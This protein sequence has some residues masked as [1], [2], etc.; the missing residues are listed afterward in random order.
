MRR[1]VG[2]GLAAMFTFICGSSFARDEGPQITLRPLGG[3]LIGDGHTDYE[4]QVKVIARLV[5]RRLRVGAEEGQVL[6]VGEMIDG[7]ATF[8]YKP[9]KVDDA[10]EVR[11]RIVTY[12]GKRRIKR[13]IDLRV[14][15]PPEDGVDEFAVPT[16]VSGPEPPPDPPSED[17]SPSKV[18]KQTMENHEI[19]RVAGL[20]EEDTKVEGEMPSSVLAHSTSLLLLGVGAGYVT[21]FGLLGGPVVRVSGG[22]GFKSLPRLRL[23]GGTGFAFAKARRFVSSLQTVDLT[24]WT[25][26]VVLRVAYHREL[27]QAFA[28]RGILMGGVFVSRVGSKVTVVNNG[29]QTSKSTELAP[30]VGMGIGALMKLGP[31]SFFLDLIYEYARAKGVVSGNIAGLT[32]VAGYQVGFGR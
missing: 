21:N 8:I 23:G 19:T 2:F 7:I 25:I 29:S 16:F 20:G 27:S 32:T 3:P 15:P 12:V 28:M 13:K 9:P 6:S 10:E 18:E 4:I 22:M 5:A 31:G 1:V 17:F 26:P 30:S 11:I 24:L 14:M